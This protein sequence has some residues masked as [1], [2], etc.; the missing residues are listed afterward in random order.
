MR[1]IIA[2][3]VI[4][5]GS[6]CLIAQ[7]DFEK[8][9]QKVIDSIYMAHPASVGLLVHIESP[10]NQISW[11]GASGYSNKENTTTL[12]PDQPFLIAS[13]IKTY[14]S[15]TILRLVEQKKVSIDQP[16]GE[17]IS[18]KTHTLL[19]K[20]GYDLDSIKV[21][22]LM[23]HTSGIWN[24]ANKD[25]IDHKN[26]KPDYRWTRDEQLELT[27]QGGDPLGPAGSVFNYSDA[28]Y[29]L[30]TEII[31]SLTGRSFYVAMRSLLNYEGLG[32]NSTWFPTLED[33]PEDVKE[34]AHQYW[35]EYNWDSYNL[36][37]SWDLYG[38]G[39]I[40]C[41]TADLA[42]FN[43]HYFNGDIVK[44]DSIRNL[45]FTEIKTKETELN[46]YYLGLSQGNYHG[47]NAYGHG[48][49]WGTVMMYFPSINST[50]SVCVLDRDKRI[51][52]KDIL[53]AFSK[54][55]KNAILDKQNKNQSITAYLDKLKDFSGSILIAHKDKIIEKRCYGKANIEDKVDNKSDTK[56]NLASINK[57][58][59]SVAVLQLCEQGKLNE[60]DTIGKYLPEYKNEIIRDSATIHQLLTHTSGIPPFYGKRFLETDKLRYKKVKD[61]IPL[62]EDEPLNFTPG[63]KYQY[64]GSNF[65]LLGRIIEEVTGRD[66]YHHMHT[67]VFNKAGMTN[68]LAI[69]ADSIVQNKAVGYTCL[70][71][72]QNYYSRNDHYIT[73]ASPS[74]SFYSTAE[75][76]FLFSKAIRNGGLINQ[77]SFELLTSP[78]VK[79]YNTHLGY[80][81]DIDQRYDERIIGHSGGWFG[82]R[83]E[84]MDFL[85]SD[86]TVVV[87]SNKDD[88]GKTGAS[89]VIEDIKVLIA[90]KRKILKS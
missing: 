42:K 14:V 86:Y 49:F 17:L 25:Y 38:G 3:L 55:L 47:M 54:I 72:D 69:P 79:G 77:E 45:I 73:K 62:F 67:K 78:K 51:L 75:D 35:G 44:N 76:L 41:T 34:L 30:L 61:F 10:D 2:I 87:L 1:K 9:F 85:A 90:G 37:V 56:F 68:T 81:I 28:N 59:T 32:L 39:G 33:K 89:K 46:P 13:S 11:S 84:L 4:T 6:S 31:E 40:A 58:I 80:G 63:E 50:I 24:Y 88:D 60:N 19:K 16:I 43:Y 21:K 27:T 5:L 7:T 26:Q 48:G 36:D 20:D 29:L 18:K 65:A 53:E 15:A 66:Y 23:S 83:T 71:G 8:R 64:S 52:R 12:E 82:V 74:A 57:L 22:H 70:W